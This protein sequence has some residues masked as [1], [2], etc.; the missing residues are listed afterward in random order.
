L[1]ELRLLDLHDEIRVREY[2]RS[3]RRDRGASG[4]VL[5]IADADT[6]ARLGFHEDLVARGGE[7]PDTSRNET[8]AIFV[9]LDLPGDTDAHGQDSVKWLAD[10]P[11]GAGPARVCD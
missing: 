10:K 5:H 8:D 2:L 4:L 9:N 3:V 6:G 7:L 1:D 11:K